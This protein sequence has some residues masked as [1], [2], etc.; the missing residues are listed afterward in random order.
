LPGDRVL[1]AT[2]SSAAVI[3]GLDNQIG[4]ITPGA[5]AD[6][7]LVNGDPLSKASDALSIVAVVRNGRFFSL[8]SLLERAAASTGVE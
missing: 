7:V 8:V 2:G 1:Q 6:L 3:L 5:V 4:R